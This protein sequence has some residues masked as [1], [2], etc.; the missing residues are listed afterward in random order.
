MRGSHKYVIQC[1]ALVKYWNNFWLSKPLGLDRADLIRFRVDNAG[2]FQRVAMN[3]NMTVGQASFRL[4]CRFD[5]LKTRWLR[6]VFA[7]SYRLYVWIRRKNY[8]LFV[9][10]MYLL[11]AWG[12]TITDKSYV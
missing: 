1:A 4:L 10:E 3:L 7:E 8:W 9:F 5:M 2:V 6:P 12:C 11:K